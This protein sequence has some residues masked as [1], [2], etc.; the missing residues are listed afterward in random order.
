MN[1]S[2]T[3]GFLILHVPSYIINNYSYKPKKIK[4]MYSNY[5]YVLDARI[6]INILMGEKMTCREEDTCTWGWG[7]RQILLTWKQIWCFLSQ[8]YI[9]RSSYR[10]Q[11]HPQVH[12]SVWFS[13]PTI[14]S[15]KS[16]TN[17]IFAYHLLS[18]KFNNNKQNGKSS[19]LW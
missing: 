5:K 6:I 3:R 7:R 13:E 2:V 1:I 9:Y 16:F 12:F 4:C 14:T 10:P 18:I 15:I 11:Y 8:L 17:S 19:L